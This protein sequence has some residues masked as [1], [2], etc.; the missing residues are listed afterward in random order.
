MIQQNFKTERYYWDTYVR[1]NLKDKVS[2]T[3]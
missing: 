1:W 3:V 2:D